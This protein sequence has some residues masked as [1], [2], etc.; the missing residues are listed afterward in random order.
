GRRRRRGDI[1][2]AETWIKERR[3]GGVARIPAVPVVRGLP[4]HGAGQAA[5]VVKTKLAQP[6][7]SVGAPADAAGRR[8]KDTVAGANDGLIPNTV[9][10]A[11]ARSGIDV[12][13]LDGS[14]AMAAI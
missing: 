9:G 1:A 13:L 12:V 3:V 8:V 4:G 2:H 6:L 14:P 10:N 11:Y 7:A 5:A